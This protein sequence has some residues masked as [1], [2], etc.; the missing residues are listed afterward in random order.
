MFVDEKRM[1]G[2]AAAVAL[3][4]T[5]YWYWLTSLVIFALTYTLTGLV[6]ALGFALADRGE[7]HSTA[8]EERK[9]QFCASLH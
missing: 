6:L 8:Q 1:I 3:V 4:A 5:L 7:E 9:K 2:V